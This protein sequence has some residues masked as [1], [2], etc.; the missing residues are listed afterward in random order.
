M[1]SK[2]L[3]ISLLEVVV[4]MLILATSVLGISQGQVLL[5]RSVDNVM[6]TTQALAIAESQIE[7]VYADIY[8]TN[9]NSELSKLAYQHQ[10]VEFDAPPFEIQ[11]TIEPVLLLNLISVRVSVGWGDDIEQNERVELQTQ[12]ALF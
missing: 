6:M 9:M 11:R 7:Q 12:I 3:G 5:S 8:A 10:T 1:I 4:S 2:C